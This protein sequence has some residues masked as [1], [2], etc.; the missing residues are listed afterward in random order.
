[1]KA[2]CLMIA[3]VLAISCM[4][5]TIDVDAALPDDIFAQAEY[6]MAEQVNDEL[7]VSFFLI[8]RQKKPFKERE[9]ERF[10]L[11]GLDDARTQ[12]L[13]VEA[14][15]ELE[16]YYTTS[17]VGKLYFCQAGHY[18]TG[19][20]V[21]YFRGGDSQRYP[22]GRFVTDIFEEEGSDALYTYATTA[23]SSN[24]DLYNCRYEIKKENI[25]LIELGIDVLAK[26]EV[27]LREENEREIK[28]E[29]AFESELPS[30]FRFIQPSVLI[31]DDGAIKRV[32]AKVG[33]TCGGLG[34]SEE[35][36]LT[37]YRAWHMSDM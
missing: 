36:V 2:I 4:S 19:E 11:V 16:N 29:I 7:Y 33:C 23:M 22:I 15:A 17:L 27:I 14:G 9:I 8:H 20:I 30:V 26:Q 3:M 18:E 34:I 10:E 28:L 31:Q 32:Y 35:E 13:R 6:Y 12:V 37:A 25:E 5:Y 1:M 21:L 24:P